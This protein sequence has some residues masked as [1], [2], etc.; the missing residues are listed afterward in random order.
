VSVKKWH[1]MPELC[2][3]DNSHSHGKRGKGTLRKENVIVGI[4]AIRVILLVN[5]FNTAWST[6]AVKC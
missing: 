5:S 3:Q 4:M 6:L 2:S 1:I